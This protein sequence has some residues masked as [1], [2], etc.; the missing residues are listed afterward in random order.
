MV[1]IEGFAHYAPIEK[2]RA[3]FA[4]RVFCVSK[5]KDATVHQ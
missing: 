4:L 1:E 3:G 5:P 2:K